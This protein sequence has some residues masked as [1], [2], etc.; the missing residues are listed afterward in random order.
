M[1]RIYKQVKINFIV[2][3]KFMQLF[4]K[5]QHVTWKGLTCMI[6]DLIV[7]DDNHTT[8]V[9]EHDS[10]VYAVDETEVGVCKEL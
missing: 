7:D 1:T 3:E 5:Q 6:S 10:Q 4:Q 8:Y 9:L 2:E